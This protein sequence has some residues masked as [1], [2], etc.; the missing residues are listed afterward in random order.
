MGKHGK[1]NENTQTHKVYSIQHRHKEEKRAHEADSTKPNLG[2]TRVD[3]AQAQHA[4]TMRKAIARRCH[5]GV[6][7]PRVCPYPSPY[8]SPPATTCHPLAI[9]PRRLHANQGNI[10]PTTDH[11]ATINRWGRPSHSTHLHLSFILHR[12]L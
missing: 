11:S 2:Q 12:H 7:A 1:Y 6:A 8:L 9:P 5:Q 3:A 10:L 4:T